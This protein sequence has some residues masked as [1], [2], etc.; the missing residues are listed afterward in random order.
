MSIATAGRCQNYRALANNTDRCAVAA[1]CRERRLFGSGVS[2][3]GAAR[4][5]P[6]LLL[7]CSRGRVERLNGLRCFG[8]REERWWSN[9]RR[10]K[11]I[12]HQRVRQGN[13]QIYT[14]SVFMFTGSSHVLKAIRPTENIARWPLSHSCGKHS[15]QGEHIT[16]LFCGR[17][18]P[19]ENVAQTKS[20]PTKRRQGKIV[21]WYV[22]WNSLRYTERPN[23]EV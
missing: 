21:I 18:F 2:S 1:C 13:A 22:P 15:W 23:V 6:S 9:K 14:V 7:S 10:Q 8:K 17:P 5:R 20:Y 4:S 3:S 11:E 19:V 16:P 12:K